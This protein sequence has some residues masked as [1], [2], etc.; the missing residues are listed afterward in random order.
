[1]IQLDET[2][3]SVV[4]LVGAAL[5]SANL[6][7]GDVDHVSAHGTATVANDRTES[8]ALRTLFGSRCDDLPVTALKSMTGHAIAGSG[9]M[10]TAALAMSIREGVM[11][12]TI[13]YDTPDPECPVLIVGNEAWKRQANV[14]LKLSYAFGGH[15][16]C[17]VLTRV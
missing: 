6:A 16:A 4:K 5:R 1:M 3:N 7:L 14:C 12:P 15:N 8:R 13:N 9:A 11:T 2:G 10:E 17:L